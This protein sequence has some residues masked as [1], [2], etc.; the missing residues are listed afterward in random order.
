MYNSNT[1]K[2][3]YRRPEVRVRPDRGRRAGAAAYVQQQLR[4][5]TTVPFES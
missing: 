1:A 3:L 2:V 4:W 5:S